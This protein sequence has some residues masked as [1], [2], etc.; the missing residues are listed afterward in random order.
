MNRHWFL[1]AMR[2]Q[3]TAFDPSYVTFRPAMH[4]QTG[5]EVSRIGRLRST[6]PFRMDQIAASTDRARIEIRADD[7]PRA[8]APEI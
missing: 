4:T 6:L 8:Q 7:T 3:S 2:A 1:T 5:C